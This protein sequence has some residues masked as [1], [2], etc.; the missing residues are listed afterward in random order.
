MGEQQDSLLVWMHHLK[1][2]GPQVCT[3]ANMGSRVMRKSLLHFVQTGL[4]EHTYKCTLFDRGLGEWLWSM[5]NPRITL[6][7]ASWS[8]TI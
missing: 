8:E 3:D 4:D 6:L 2:V 1:E 5:L 7:A